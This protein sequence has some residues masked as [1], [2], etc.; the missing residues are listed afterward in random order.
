[1]STKH[2]CPVEDGDASPGTAPALGRARPSVPHDRSPT[3]P[4]L[5]LLAP[6]GA[7]AQA[8]TSIYCVVT[9]IDDRGRLADRSPVKALG[10]AAGQPV[11]SQPAQDH[12][13]LAAD[14]AG[15][16]AV[17]RQGF[18]RLPIPVRRM[19]QLTAGD[20]LLVVT[21]ATEDLMIVYTM[22]AVQR[23]SAPALASDRERGSS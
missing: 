14:A 15:D 23:L 19:L 8:F 17:N 22:S 1:M 6:R 4:P 10:W 21:D 20:R 2:P 16:P 11:T 12:V 3:A 5:G 7:T 13:M 18:L 9:T